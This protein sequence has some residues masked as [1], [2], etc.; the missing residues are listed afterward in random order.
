MHLHTI[1]QPGAS[2]ESHIYNAHLLGMQYIRFTDHDVRTGISQN[3]VT[4]FD[5][6]KGAIEYETDRG[7]VVGWKK[8]G[9]GDLEVSPG[10]FK[11]SA[12][13]DF[14]GIELYSG[15]K[16]HTASLL[17]DMS[18]TLAFSHTC[19]EES[20]V[21]LDISLSQRPPDHKEG[22][23]R[24]VI[25]K[26]PEDTLPH[27]FTNPILPREDNIYRL[28]ISEDIG[29]CAEV[30]GLDNV[31]ATI[32]VIATKNA[33]VTLRRLNIERKYSFDDVIK[34]QRVLGIKVGEKYGITP[35]VTTEI[36]GAGQ[37]KNCFTSSVPVISYK[38]RDEI[39]EKEAIEHVKRHG[40]IFSYNHPFE[41]DQ[42]KRR[43]FTREE[44]DR[45]VAER[46]AELIGS[47][48]YGASVT[49]VGFP[50][51]RGLFT[52]ADHLKIWDNLSLAGVFITGDGDSDC[53]KSHELWFDGNNFATYI[54]ASDNS[55]TPISEEEF[56]RSL[57]NGNVYMGDP[58]FAPRDVRFTVDG[59]KMGSVITVKKEKYTAS[60]SFTNTEEGMTVRFITDGKCARCEAVRK[61]EYSTELV[62]EPQGAVSFVRAE[63]YRNDRCV[64]LTNPIYFVTDAF[65]GDIPK[66][67][68]VEI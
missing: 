3:S 39:S 2:M 53:H 46:S 58:L 4:E 10:E 28:N 13:G 19:D 56:N 38:E 34:R 45:I 35:F 65:S 21:I 68:L 52:L 67:R 6:S 1:H 60:L 54:A 32:T 62:I 55:S 31:F 8:S 23:Y 43:Q 57:I 24:Y 11:L 26:I 66:E 18:I 29:K 15:S 33:T 7:I 5:F 40:G 12:N 59:A 51:G 47:R 20:S 16:L 37:H 48:V 63:L 61:G 27:S 41:A 25:G 36:T 9:C 49:E 14:V 22:H 17:S 42:Y 44:L 64:M 30:G 50:E